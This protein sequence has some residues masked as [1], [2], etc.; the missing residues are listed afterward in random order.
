MRLRKSEAKT[1]RYE[2]DL[3]NKRGERRVIEFVCWRK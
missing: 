2:H 1:G 3:K